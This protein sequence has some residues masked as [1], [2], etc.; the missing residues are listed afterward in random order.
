MS[1]FYLRLPDGG[2]QESFHRGGGLGV[3]HSHPLSQLIE[4]KNKAVLLAGAVGPETGW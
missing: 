2:S 3:P 1:P 4:I